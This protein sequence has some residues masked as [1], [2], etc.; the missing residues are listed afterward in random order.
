MIHT[1]TSAAPNYLGKVRAL[2]QSLRLHL[3]GAQLHW[4]VVDRPSDALR[5]VLD[6]DMAEEVDGVR[7][8]T[9]FETFQ[10]PGW[11]FQRQGVELATV[12]KAFMARELM[13]RDDCDTVLY[14]DPDV[15][16]FSPLDDVLDQLATASLTLT[17][18]LLHPAD[19]REAVR[20]HELCALRHGVFNLGF[21]GVRNCPEGQEF[22][23]WW[24]ERCLLSCE[25]PWRRDGYT[26]QRWM[27]FAPTFFPGTTICRS[28]RLNV[29][30]WNLDQRSLVGTFDEGFTVEGEPLG[31]YHFTGFD[32]GA[33]RT[34]VDHWAPDNPS[35]SA[36]LEWY[37]RRIDHL[38]GDM[39]WGLEHYADGVPI[40]AVARKLYR[41]RE[42]L[43]EQYPDP[44]AVTPDEDESCF[45]WWYRTVA[46]YEYPELPKLEKQMRLPEEP[47]E[48][49]LPG[50]PRTADP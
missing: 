46:P 19:S 12:G 34:M 7:H 23:T 11:L 37:T 45:Q 20:V 8:I 42:D 16:V 27:D 41:D 47:L 40:T 14:F 48:R 39:P 18:H 33:H 31:F 15:V 10:D 32:S 3:P 38:D 21:L 30:P 22:L 9:D 5:T 13:D 43:R 28:P 17:P 25:F 49:W 2:L 29:A 35:L 24:R 1:F 4:L 6:G 36:I 26:A 44:Y 50:D